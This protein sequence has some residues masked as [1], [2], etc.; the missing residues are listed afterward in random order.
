MKV[1]RNITKNPLIV[2]TGE[3]TGR[4]PENRYFV[5][6]KTIKNNVEWGIRNKSISLENYNRIFKEIKEYLDETKTFS[7]T[8]NVCAEN[9]YQYEIELKTNVE[10]YVS[11]AENMFRKDSIYKKNNVIKILHAPNFKSKY[12]LNELNG[13]NFIIIDLKNYYI[14]IGGTGYAGE[15]KK[16]VFSLLNYHLPEQGVL[17]MHCSANYDSKY[18]TSIFF[19]LSGTGKTTLSLDSNKLLI[20]DDEHGWSSNGIFNIEG[21][22]YAKVIGLNKIQEP[23]IF[24]ATHS[25]NA[26]I[27]NVL[28]YAER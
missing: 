18:G 20:G 3:F 15:I 17:P 1:I 7:F 21:G 24:E 22:C 12:N 10:W 28:K 6:Q 23:E 4:S 25:Q 16:A 19:G 27:E 14:L 13:K 8:G 26:I 2:H 9:D 11:F 5:D